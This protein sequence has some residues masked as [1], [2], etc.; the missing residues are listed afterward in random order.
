MFHRRLSLR[1]DEGVKHDKAPALPPIAKS[2]GAN[3]Y[4]SA[5]EEEGNLQ[6]LPQTAGRRRAALPA[7]GGPFTA[8]LISSAQTSQTGPS[9][10]ARFSCELLYSKFVTKMV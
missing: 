10:A 2:G 8:L 7:D 9:F 6:V 3:K 5:F 1:R 4:L